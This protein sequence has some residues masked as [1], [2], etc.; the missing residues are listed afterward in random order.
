MRRQR[1]MTRRGFLRRAAVAAAGTVAAPYVLTSAALGAAGRQAASER[2]TLGFVGTGSHGIGRNLRNFLPQPDAQVVALCDVDARHVRSARD[3]TVQQ[4]A[5][6][7]RAGTFHGVDVTG[8]WRTVVAR[9]DVDAVMVSTPDHWHVLP[10]LAAIKA[11]KDVICEKPLTLTVQEGRVLSD[12]VRRY[13]RIFQTASENRSKGNFLRACELVRNGRIGKLHTIR[14]EL[15]RGGRSGRQPTKPVPEGLD[16]DMWLGPAPYRPYCDFGNN[17]CHYQWRWIFDYSGGQL[18]DWGAHINDVAQWGNDTERTGPTTVEGRGVF[19]DDGLWNTAT[20][21]EVTFEYANGVRLICKSGTPS[22]RFEGS[23]GWV[24][25][26]WDSI[27]TH[28]ASLLRSLIG[29][30]EIRL[31][32]CPQGEH[33]DFLNCVKTRQQTYYPAEVGHRSVTLSHL[34]NIS[35]ILGRKLR[36]DPDAERFHNDAQANRMLSRAMREPWSL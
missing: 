16:W 33:R 10:S 14:T 35:M 7:R 9:S 32:T 23:D 8:D 17:R 31:R 22:I 13:G 29:P 20:D 3:L 36:W 25:C 11:G 6:R 28:P 19:P 15:P 5:A 24:F 2:I 12:A 30:D 4:Y 18:T 34:G 1:A 21:Y 27:Q 26:T